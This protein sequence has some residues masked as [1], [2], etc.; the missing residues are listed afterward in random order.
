MTTINIRITENI[1]CSTQPLRHWFHFPIHTEKMWLCYSDK[2]VEGGVKVVIH[3]V[4]CTVEGYGGGYIYS[5]LR[6]KLYRAFKQTRFFHFTLYFWVEYE[7][8]A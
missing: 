8:E 4:G 7:V 1:C 3:E 2:P 5:H 6:Q